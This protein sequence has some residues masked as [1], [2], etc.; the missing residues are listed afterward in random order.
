MILANRVLSTYTADVSGVCSAMYELGGMTV[1]HDASGCNSTYNTHDEPRWYDTES[2]VFISALTEADAILGADDKLIADVVQ[3]AGELRPKFITICGTPI[4]MLSGTDFPGVATVVEQETGIP[5]IGLDTNGMH[6]YQ[7]GAGKAFCAFAGRFV[8]PAAAWEPVRPGDSEVRV[9][10]LGATPLDF[11]VTGSVEAIRDACSDRG[12]EVLSCWAMGS[13]FLQLTQA[14][15]AQVNCV[16]STAGLSVARA[17]RRRFGTPFVVGLPMGRRGADRYFACVT[18][19]A[20]TGENSLGILNPD[21]GNGSDTVI[22]GE[23]VYS[24]ALRTAMAAAGRGDARVLCPL[25]AERET[26]APRDRMIAN[27]A[28]IVRA[29]ET[30]RTVI[31]DP[32]YRPVV[33]KGARFVELPHEAYSGRMFRDRIPVLIGEKMERWMEENLQ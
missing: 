6:S 8:E 24:A 2:L 22:V 10:L 20:R 28:G 11:S 27:E 21:A 31:A 26:L 4:P 9:N 33:P 14:G 29:L 15:R 25:E 32:L 18:E 3:A 19:A 17:L 13:D 16:L 5:A 23:A 7:I 1:M 30:A 12:L